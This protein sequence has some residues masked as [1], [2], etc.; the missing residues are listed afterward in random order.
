MQLCIKDF[1]TPAAAPRRRRGGGPP[2][3]VDLFAGLGGASTGAAQAGYEVVLAVDS[4][5][6]ALQLH[7]RN[8]PKCV[9]VCCR[10][11]PTTPLS[12]PSKDEDWHLHGSPPCTEVSIAN[13]SR[14]DA[15]RTDAVGLI[16]WYV[17]FALASSATTWSLEQVGTPIVMRYLASLK[18]PKSPHRNR[19]AYA[20]VNFYD[21]GVPQERRRVIAGSPEIVASLLR[22]AAWHQCIADVIPAPRGTHVRSW[23]RWSNPKPHP[24]K[25]GKWVYRE[26][27]DDE[28]CA[29]ITGPARC[30]V[31]QHPLRWARPHTQTKLVALTPREQAA[32]QCFPPAYDLG[33][34][35]ET[36][37]RCVGNALP[38]LIMKQLLPR[39][40]GR[41][42]RKKKRV[43]QS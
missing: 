21:Y 39:K 13:Q 3:F 37:I 14:I 17:E 25:P 23:M 19:V 29:P 15:K 16:R 40:P 11:P 2:K 36:A 8:H 5:K 32:L 4:D 18:A 31:A 20:V 10:L 33:T 6:K 1:L 28:S 9:H 26:Y 34:H 38:P 22:V 27:T 35:R 30:V 7:A 24:T 41:A 42:I 43:C 12:L